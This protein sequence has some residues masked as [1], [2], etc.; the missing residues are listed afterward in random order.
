MLYQKKDVVLV[1]SV[2]RRKFTQEITN[3]ILLFFIA[4]YL[5]E[6]FALREHVCGEIVN[7]IG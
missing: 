4:S 2:V 5:L 1:A 3:K 7:G 6:L